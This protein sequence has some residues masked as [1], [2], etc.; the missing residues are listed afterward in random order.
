MTYCYV[1]ASLNS[2]S[3]FL[4]PLIYKFLVLFLSSI[5]QLREQ[6][7]PRR[8]VGILADAVYND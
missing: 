1:L 6:Q 7:L 3:W 5:A 8:F 2:V 4:T